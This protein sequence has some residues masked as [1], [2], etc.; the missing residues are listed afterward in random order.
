MQLQAQLVHADGE[1]RV[2]LV[3]ARE[4]DRLLGSALGEA[5]GAEEAEDR[6]LARLLD[7]LGPQNQP[8]EHP[9]PPPLSTPTSPR[10]VAARTGSPA[11]RPPHQHSIEVQPPDPQPPEAQAAQMQAPEEPAVDP[12]DWSAELAQLD[13]EMG[14]L[15]WSREMEGAYLQ[16]SFGHPSR[17]RLTAYADL[18]AY[19]R[20][21][22]ALE[23]GGDPTTAPIPLRRSDLLS[24]CDQ[25]L[26]QLGWDG[27][28][29]RRFLE[30]SLAVTSRQHLSDQQL[31]HFNMLLETELIGTPE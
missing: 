30:E 19:L 25:L 6:A 3:T 8:A 24:Q 27:E 5:A 20:A 9:A 11:E 16:R 22:E 2:V 31:L 13:L 26:D 4:G 14:R 1:R 23:P 10:R 18:L 28:R 15:G 7:R 29:G 12:E 21:I 17:H